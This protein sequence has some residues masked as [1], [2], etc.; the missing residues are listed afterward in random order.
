[1]S[2]NPFQEWWATAIAQAHIFAARL[3]ERSTA[4]MQTLI[5]F[6]W[7]FFIAVLLGQLGTV[8]IL[9]SAWWDKDSTVATALSNQV[10]SGNFIV[11]T[12][13]LLSSSAYFLV[14]EYTRGDRIEKSGLKSGLLLLSVVLGLVGTLIAFKLMVSKE[15]VEP[16]QL[17]VHWLVYFASLVLAVALW[18]LEEQNSTQK[19]VKKIAENAEGITLASEQSRT[20]SGVK[21]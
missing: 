17:F 4:A 20:N 19:F 18:M 10:S 14:K 12:T 7:F 8:M 13:A 11:F 6:C 5:S 9:F 1:M 21:V 3:K 15:D 2:K 16:A